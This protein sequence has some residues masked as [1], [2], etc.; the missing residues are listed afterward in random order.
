V[1]AEDGRIH[2]AC[3]DDRYVE[4]LALQRDGGPEVAAAEFAVEGADEAG[5]S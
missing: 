4:L 5:R 1:R 3:G 2:V